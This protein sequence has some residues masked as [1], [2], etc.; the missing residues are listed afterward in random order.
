MGFFSKFEGKMEDT[1]EGGAS[2]MQKSPISPVQIMK[3]A[4]KQ[5]RREK[6]VSAG[7]QF[8]PTLYTVLV[9]P[10]DDQRLFGFYPTLA[11]ECETRL[12]SSAAGEG[13]SMDGHPL[14]RFI[15]DDGL[16]HGKFDVIAE[17]V[18]APIVAQLRAEEMQRYGMGGAVGTPAPQAAAYNDPAMARAQQP[19]QAPQY[20]PQPPMPG[21]AYGAAPQGDYGQQIFGAP[22]AYNDPAMA[23]AQQPQQAPQYRPQPPMPGNAYGAAPQGDYGQQIF[24]APNAGAFPDV[25]EKPAAKPPLPYVPE[26]EIDYSIDYGEYT[27]DSKN[28]EDYR[29]KAPQDESEEAAEAAQADTP[30]NDAQPQNLPEHARQAS[31]AAEAGVEA[32]GMYAPQGFEGQPLPNPAFPQGYNP[33]AQAYN[34]Y[35][36]GYAPQ[37]YAGQ[38]MQQPYPGAAPMGMQPQG[39]PAYGAPAHTVAFAAGAAQANPV[40]NGAAVRARLIDA[41]SNRSYDLATNR[42]LVGRE[43]GNDIVLNDLNVS[44]QHAQLAFEP[45][46][47]W[48]ITDLGSTNG[49]FVNGMPVTRRGLAD[50]DRITLGMTE[51]VFSMR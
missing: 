30:E 32:A 23:R 31:P 8:A 17:V 16:K 4:E 15:V 22:A 2:K 40:P 24:G 49:T 1:F 13:L 10:D 21:N 39:A 45:Q 12:A 20:R 19:Q 46:G 11:G 43:T 3:K 7:K 48:V 41:N 29:D 26:N 51:F 34:P 38:P 42:I 14:V 5:M 35:A 44:R 18:S 27:F 36:A 6:V 50:G 25:Q 37:P 47:V 33:Q 28:F 9:N